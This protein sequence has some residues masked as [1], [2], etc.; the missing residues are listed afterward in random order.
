MARTMKWPPIPE[1]G[2]I[3]MIDGGEATRAVVM[4]TLSDLQTNPFNPIDLSLGEVTFRVK[5]AVRSRIYGAL[6]RMR[7]MV[8]IEN[9]DQVDDGERTT[10]TI[11][12]VDLETREQGSVTIDG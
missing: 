10:I 6:N 4:Q 12:Y 9:I 11:N 8:R 2:R 1:G 5:S 3:P 7:S